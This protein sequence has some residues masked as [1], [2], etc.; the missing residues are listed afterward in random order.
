MRP[1]RSQF[2]SGG[3]T[4]IQCSSPYCNR[5]GSRSHTNDSLSRLSGCVNPQSGQRREVFSGATCSTL[6]PYS[7]GLYSTYAYNRLNAHL[8]PHDAPVRSRM[9]VKSSNAIAEQSWVRASATNSF[10]IRWSVTLNRSSSLRPIDWMLSCAHRVPC[11][12]K[13][14]RRFSY[15]RRQ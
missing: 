9:S 4:A 8:W 15:S 13:S 6:M 5:R 12:C 11:S 2:D 7:A 10:E 1:H 14:P 3:D